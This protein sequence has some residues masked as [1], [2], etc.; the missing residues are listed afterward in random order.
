M[1]YIHPNETSA[2]CLYLA[3][4]HNAVN[5]GERRT[6]LLPVS[7]GC[8]RRADALLGC[9]T[10]KSCTKQLIARGLHTSTIPQADLDTYA[11]DA[12]T[13]VFQHLTA[14]D[15]RLTT[16]SAGLGDDFTEMDSAQFARVMQW[17]GTVIPIGTQ[18]FS[19]STYQEALAESAAEPS[20]KMLDE[21][22]RP[23]CQKLTSYVDVPEVVQCALTAGHGTECDTLPDT[24][25]A[26]MLHG[27]RQ[28]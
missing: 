13:A 22:G 19:S 6:M 7:Y 5:A 23:R 9:G 26:P 10:C 18:V 15:P 4:L 8:T 20:L 17:A 24:A 2:W 28:W 16:G 27:G 21:W 11:N 14:L 3:A 1:F 25:T 12:A